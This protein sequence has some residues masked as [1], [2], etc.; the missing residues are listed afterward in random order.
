MSFCK[1]KL[2]GKNKK[3]SKLAMNK[4]ERKEIERKTREEKRRGTTIIVRTELINQLNIREVEITKN[5][6][7]EIIEITIDDKKYAIIAI[8]AELERK[9]K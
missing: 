5:S 9:K 7:I 8:H 6:E 3:L 1:K 4:K 2:V